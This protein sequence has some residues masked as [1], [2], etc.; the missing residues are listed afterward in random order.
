M[1][2]LA[3][4]ILF[5]A[6]KTSIAFTV[7]ALC[8]FLLARI[9]GSVVLAWSGIMAW[10][11]AVI[12]FVFH[13]C[14]GSR[15]GAMR[16]QTEGLSPYAALYL[17]VACILKF[18]GRLLLGVGVYWRSLAVPCIYFGPLVLTDLPTREALMFGVFLVLCAFALYCGAYA[19][20][21]FLLLLARR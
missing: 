10:L 14:G 7:P 11:V 15:Y 1:T 13:I 19:L 3:D 5:A 16:V 2:A 4:R 6:I 9:S 12:L 20:F 8:G 17:P 21:G 18:L